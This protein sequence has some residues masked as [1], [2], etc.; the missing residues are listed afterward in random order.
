MPRFLEKNHKMFN[1]RHVNIKGITYLRAE[2]VVSY[3]QEIA[4]TEETDVRNRLNEA[5]NNLRKGT[6]GCR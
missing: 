4:A 1:I 6:P 3:I 2:D 5:A